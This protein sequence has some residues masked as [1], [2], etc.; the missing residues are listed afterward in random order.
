MDQ[1]ASGLIDLMIIEQHKLIKIW[2]LLP[3]VVGSTL[4]SQALPGKSLPVFTRDY[5]GDRGG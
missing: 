2:D 5:A 4:T 1:N 3:Y